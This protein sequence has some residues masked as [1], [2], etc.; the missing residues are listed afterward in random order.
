MRVPVYSVVPFMVSLYGHARKVFKVS[1]F[2]LTLPS[3]SFGEQDSVSFG[4]GIVCNFGYEKGT[5][6]DKKTSREESDRNRC[7]IMQWKMNE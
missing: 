6:C 4:R 5:V 2:M 1:L 3:L 7:G